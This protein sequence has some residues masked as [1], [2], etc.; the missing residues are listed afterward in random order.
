MG[1]SLW[2]RKKSD[3]TE[4]LNMQAQ[5]P[6]FLPEF[7]G[8]SDPPGVPYILEQHSPNSFLSIHCIP[9]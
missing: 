9:E 6:L 3:T 7:S 8:D 4:G 2:G 1:Y 5:R